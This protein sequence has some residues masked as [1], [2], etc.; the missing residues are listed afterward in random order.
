MMCKSSRANTVVSAKEPSE[1]PE[2]RPDPI[3]K[4]AKIG[5]GMKLGKTEV[6][7]V[8]ENEG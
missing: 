3:I 8:D 7:L 6:L 5:A 2:E 4:K 1:E